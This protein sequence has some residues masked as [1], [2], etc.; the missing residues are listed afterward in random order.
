MLFS[1][2]FARI[3]IG[4]FYH[5]LHSFILQLEQNKTKKQWQKKKKHTTKPTPKTTKTKT[6]NIN[7]KTNPPKPHN[8]TQN[9]T[10]LERS[11]DLECSEIYTLNVMHH[12]SCMSILFKKMK[13]LQKMYL[14]FSSQYL[15]LLSFGPTLNS[16]NSQLQGCCSGS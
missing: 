3:F 14:K 9:T 2:K 10:Q 12:L 11:Q 7:Q 6:H 1:N 13:I 16:K 4:V 5:Q 8:W 15:L